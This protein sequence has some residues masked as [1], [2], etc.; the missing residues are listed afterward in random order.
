[1]PL[2]CRSAKACNTKQI[3]CAS[4]TGS[5]LFATNLH[6]RKQPTIT[7]I[8]RANTRRGANLVPGNGDEICAERVE[9][10]CQLPKRLA[11]VDVQH[12]PVPRAD[13]RNRLDRLNDSDFVVGPLHA[14]QRVSIRNNILERC[15]IDEPVDIHTHGGER[16]TR[17]RLALASSRYC[18]MLDRGGD[19]GGRW[20]TRAAGR[21]NEVVATLRRAAGEEQP[22]GI[23]VR[24]R[25]HRVT[26][27]GE[28]GPG[29]AP[30]HMW[31]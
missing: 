5:F 18:G 8:E 1:M 7:H 31:T 11:S 19:D 29:T 4:A 14:D 27:V 6:R 24:E 2:G 15:Q 22:F 9:V 17:A 21:T 30:D 12:G 25:C 23:A 3:L 20:R 16:P 26:R 13:R 28:D 10:N